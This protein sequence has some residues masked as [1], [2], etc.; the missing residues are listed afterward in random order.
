MDQQPSCIQS[1]TALLE[2]STDLGL[3]NLLLLVGWFSPSS[4]FHVCVVY[5]KYVSSRIFCF[6]GFYFAWG[7][8]FVC[9]RL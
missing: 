9:F 1:F 4:Y 8:L 7:G 6:I 3:V 2:N 5:L